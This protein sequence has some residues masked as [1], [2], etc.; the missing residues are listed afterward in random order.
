MRFLQQNIFGPIAVGVILMCA[1]LP[2]S[3]QNGKLQ[4][5]NLEKLSAKAAEVNDVTL[6]GALL[7]LP[8]NFLT[9]RTTPMR[10]KSRA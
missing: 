6:D 4:L 5:Q 7:Q 2:S 3:A 9:R 8:P 1:A 10:A